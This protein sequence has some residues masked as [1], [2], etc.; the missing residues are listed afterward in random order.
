PTQLRTRPGR[1]ARGA[2]ASAGPRRA[3]IRGRPHA[4]DAPTP[5]SVPTDP[6]PEGP[7]R[8]CA[9]H[10]HPPWRTFRRGSTMA[11]DGGF[12]RVVG[13][14]A[15]TAAPLA[16]ATSVLLLAAVGLI[17]AKGASML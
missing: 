12:A 13:V 8:A 6:Q 9:R 2:P 16:V 5:G 3:T 10:G 17:G 14:T 1:G 15:I 4:R 11:D 7:S